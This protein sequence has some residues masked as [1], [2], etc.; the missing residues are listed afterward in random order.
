M[1]A[2]HGRRI[3]IVLLILCGMAAH[4]CQCNDDPNIA[5][6]NAASIPD[7]PTLNLVQLAT[8]V[9]IPRKITVAV[10]LSTPSALKRLDYEL[11]WDGDVLQYLDSRPEESLGRDVSFVALAATE[12]EGRLQLSQAWINDNAAPGSNL[13]LCNVSFT[14]RAPAGL[15]TGIMLDKIKVRGVRGEIDAAQP[16][17]LV[18]RIE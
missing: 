15:E 14:V 6:P 10:D 12:D 11:V 8:P 18:L 2:S 1:G 3:V 9:E 4:G 5:K 16:A 17:G 13:R 7:R